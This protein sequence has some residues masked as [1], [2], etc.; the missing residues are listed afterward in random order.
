MTQ[1]IKAFKFP[2]WDEMVERNR[3]FLERGEYK[4]YHLQVPVSDNLYLLIDCQ[5]E[6][7]VFPNN[8]NVIRFA[9]STKN[10]FAI[11]SVRYVNCEAG[12]LMGCAHLV[13]M[14]NEFK[15]CFEEF[16]GSNV[17]DVR[18]RINRYQ[19]E[20]PEP[21]PAESIIKSNEEE[22]ISHG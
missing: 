14:A 16:T 8:E 7:C 21:E 19:T 2:T 11:T 3:P 12:Y 15:K 10:E 6:A 4:G 5:N 1:E 22:D 20:Y 18:R 9:W 17:F 13:N